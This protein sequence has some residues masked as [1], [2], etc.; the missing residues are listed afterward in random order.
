MTY[1][2]R[3]RA[4]NCGHIDVSLA[5]QLCFLLDALVQACDYSLS[6]YAKSSNY[7]KNT[8]FQLSL[9]PNRYMGKICLGQFDIYIGTPDCERS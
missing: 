8:P 4:D 6:I 2:L 9:L 1:F 3:S 5:A 7:M